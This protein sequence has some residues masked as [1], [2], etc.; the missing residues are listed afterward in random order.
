MMPTETPAPPPPFLALCLIK[1]TARQNLLAAP[2]AAA[3]V[4]GTAVNRAVLSVTLRSADATWVYG[5]NAAQVSGWVS[6]ASVACTVPIEELVVPTPTPGPVTATPIVTLTPEGTAGTTNTPGTPPTTAV[7]SPTPLVLAPTETVVEATPTE[8]ATATPQPPTATSTPA[9]APEL[10]CSVIITRGLN[11]R[12][13]PSTDF[14]AFYRLD[15]GNQFAAVGR[16]VDGR[17]L[18][19]RI[20]ETSQPGWI[21][22]TSVS[23]DGSVETLATLE[24]NV[25]PPNL[26]A[27]TPTTAPTETPTEVA[28]PTA[29]PASTGTAEAT[30]EPTTEPTTQATVV[31][32]AEPTLE[33]TPTPTPTTP[34]TAP[35]AAGEL[36]CTVGSPTGVYVRAGAS[37]SFEAFGVAKTAES[38]IATRRSANNEWLL[39][40]SELG[41]TGWVVAGGMRCTAPI[42][43][44]PVADP[45]TIQT[46]LP[47]PTGTPMG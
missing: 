36:Q 16:S 14:A 5:T 42:R 19:G 37:R 27:A 6:A 13:G 33:S 26:V 2:E 15:Q 40:T 34:P 9:T 46:P 23:C 8:V 41:L 24:N 30:A 45:A 10:L 28:A 21:I 12:R 43:N 1:T 25:L 7:V 4:V 29:T 31:P 47:K 18:G 32:T 20:V 38:F 17:W 35:A 44:L 22:A 3:Q 11:V 39:G